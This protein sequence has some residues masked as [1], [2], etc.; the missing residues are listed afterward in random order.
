VRGWG[1]TRNK[2]V[3]R[4]IGRKRQLL[5][6]QSSTPD[7]IQGFSAHKKNGK[8]LREKKKEKK[9]RAKKRA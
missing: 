4:G 9:Y 5:Q 7:W 1:K 3:E 2:G 6:N 8:M